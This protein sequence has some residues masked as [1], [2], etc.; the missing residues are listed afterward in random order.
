M[1]RLRSR[2]R[3]LAVA[4]GAFVLV[5]F[6]AGGT[7]AASNP[8]TLYA[9][10]D[11]YGN[12]RMSDVAQCKLPGGGRLVSFNTVGPTGP[13]G[14]AGPTGATGPTGPMGPKGDTGASGAPAVWFK[15]VDRADT[16]QSSWV[17]IASLSLPA[18]RYYV[19]VSATAAD[20]IGGNDDVAMSCTLE[21]SSPAMSIA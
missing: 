11:V 20:D 21:Q 6:A 16:P 15:Y 12:V 7:F 8:P 5:A 19:S 14:P 1:S 18:G 13:T 4:V 3:P 17:E 2:L 10:Y 9:C